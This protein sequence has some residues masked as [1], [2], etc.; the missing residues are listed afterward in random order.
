MRGRVAKRERGVEIDTVT[1][2]CFLFFFR[3]WRFVA[4][5]GRVLVC[6]RLFGCTEMCVRVSGLARL[7]RRCDGRLDRIVVGT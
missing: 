7:E 1:A 5:L 2:F 6:I 3:L 4:F